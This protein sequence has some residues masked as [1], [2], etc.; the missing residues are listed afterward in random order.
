MILVTGA[1][2]GLGSATLKSLI[3]LSPNSKIWGMSHRVERSVELIKLGINIR[4]GN[5]LDYES[6]VRGFQGVQTL[7][8]ISAP[9]FTDRL[10]QQTN[11][12]MA[13]IE[14]GVQ[15]IIYTSIQQKTNSKFII[16]EVTFVENA[17]KKI[18]MDSGIGYTIVNNNLYADSLAFFLGP[19]VLANGISIPTGKGRGA[20][21]SRE[22]MG[23]GL[24]ALALSNEFS[25]QEI[26]FSNNRN[27]SGEDISRIL[28][29]IHGEAVPFLNFDRQSYIRVME[30][31]GIPL[32]AAGFSADWSE[33]I[34]NGELEDCD[35]TLAGLLKRNPLS[36]EDFLYKIYS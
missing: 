22:E 31:S 6:L 36:L 26:T 34:T 3:K 13:A 5:Y 33:A 17:T 27:W 9:A 32:Q 11:A 23:E 19:N 1:T 35:A 18:I 12:V 30:Q 29:E 21:V 28:T 4:K 10:M 7:V 2:G 25:N 16:P 8:L 14:C 20:F 24:A 15:K